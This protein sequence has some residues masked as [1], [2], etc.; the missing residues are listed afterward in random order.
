HSQANEAVGKPTHAPC[1][2]PL[3]QRAPNFPSWVLRRSRNPSNRPT[4][5]AYAAAAALQ[6]LSQPQP[7]RDLLDIVDKCEEL[8]LRIHLRPS[9]ESRA[10]HA[11]VLKVAE[12]GFDGAHAS[13]VELAPHRGVKFPSHA[14]RRTI[15]DLLAFGPR[16][17][18]MFDDHQRA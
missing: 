9:T 8:P 3:R 11:L 16:A 15:L 5:R 12:D 13:A 7:A 14:F 17:L 10:P 2:T 6:D 18:P 1:A 4:R